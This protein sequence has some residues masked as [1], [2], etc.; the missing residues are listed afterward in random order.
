MRAGRAGFARAF[1]CR[2]GK[3]GTIRPAPAPQSA[4]RLPRRAR[5]A[6]GTARRPNSAARC[7]C[8]VH[9]DAAGAPIAPPRPVCAASIASEHPLLQRA[10]RPGAGRPGAPSGGERP[11]SRQR[12]DLAAGAPP[13][14]RWPPCA[15]PPA[16]RRR[17]APGGFEHAFESLKRAERRCPAHAPRR[18][19]RWHPAR[20]EAHA[21]P[22]RPL[23]PPQPPF[24]RSM[25]R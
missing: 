23:K 12:Q 25:D 22:S 2:P 13:G 21:P 16:A 8:A 5:T 18:H 19:R 15:P 9:F 17:A 6:R 4:A 14:L 3:T 7:T 24:P 20:P 10:I 1:W 11:A